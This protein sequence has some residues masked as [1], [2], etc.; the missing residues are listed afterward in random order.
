[1]LASSGYWSIGSVNQDG[2]RLATQ[3]PA[4]SFGKARRE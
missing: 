3:S 1:L 4:R 2:D